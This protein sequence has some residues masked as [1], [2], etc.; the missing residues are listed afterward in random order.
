VASIF[1]LLGAVSSLLIP[2]TIRREQNVKL[3]KGDRNV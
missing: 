1:V 2:T 3:Q